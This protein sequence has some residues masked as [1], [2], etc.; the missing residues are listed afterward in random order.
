MVFA[1]IKVNKISSG[2]TI[3]STAQTVSVNDQQTYQV[4]NLLVIDLTADLLFVLFKL[5]V[6]YSKRRRYV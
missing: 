2:N 1:V 3:Q 4:N 6:C 5:S